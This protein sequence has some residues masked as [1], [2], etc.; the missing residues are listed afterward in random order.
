MSRKMVADVNHRGKGKK[1]GEDK[2]GLMSVGRAV[3]PRGSLKQGWGRTGLFEFKKQDNNEI[4][5]R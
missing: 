1:Y 5:G 3:V 2:D 4:K